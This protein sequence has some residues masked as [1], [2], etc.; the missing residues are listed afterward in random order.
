MKMASTPA[1]ART[2][3]LAGS[4]FL[5]GQDTCD[6]PR[7]AGCGL[8]V[9]KDDGEWWVDE[10]GDYSAL[11]GGIAQWYKNTPYAFASLGQGIVT[12]VFNETQQG[13]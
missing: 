9:S 11:A 1:A 4:L 3:N 13:P 10:S 5:A 6:L 7:R 12:K 2:H 8:G